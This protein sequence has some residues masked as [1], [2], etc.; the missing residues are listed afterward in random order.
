MLGGFKIN[1]YNSF[2]SLIIIVR[3]NKKNKIIMKNN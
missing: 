3:V 1:L 2:N